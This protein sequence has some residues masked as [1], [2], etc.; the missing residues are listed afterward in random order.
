MAK[1]KKS[2]HSKKNTPEGF[3]SK[4]SLEEILPQKYHVLAVILVIFIL[5]LAFLYP[6]YFGGKTFESGD[7]IASKAMRPYVENH[8][9]GFT[10]WNPLIFC[11]MPA[12]AT[13]LGFKWFNLI[14]VS[15]ASVRD[16]FTSLFSVQ[17]T[18]WTFYLILLAIT[19][20]F[21]MKYI[22]K[23]TLVSLFSAIA[24]SF[25]TGIIVFLYIGHVTK[26]NSLCMF[27]L[28]FLMLLKFKEKIKVLDF[29]ILIIALQILLLGFHAQIIFYT[30]F[31]V[32][33]YFIFYILRS[34]FK[35]DNELR[36]SLFKSAG[37]FAVATIIAL[38]IQSDNISQIY[39]YTP[40][41]TRGTSS[42]VEKPTGQ[43][44][45][46][47]SGYYKYHTMWSFS[48]EEL[49]TFIIPSYYG[50]GSSTYQGPLTQER[51]VNVNT[52]FGQMEFVDVAMYMGI[53]VFFLA[54]F[55]VYSRRKEPFVQFLAV[56][57]IIALLISFGKNFPVVFDLL[58]Y[59]L[60]LFN[61]FRVPSMILVLV[62]LSVPILAGL[63]L[64]K[65][66]SLKDEKDAGLIKLIKNSAYIFT[67]IF[68]ISLLLKG[69][70]SDW[71]AG[72]V[73]DYAANLRGS[74][75][76]L[77]QQFQALAK[78]VASMFSGDLM[79]G[80]GILTIAFWMALAYINSKVSR[81]AFILVVIVLTILDLW[82]ID[83]RGEK[84]VDNPDVKG[85]FNQPS[86]IA[87][88]KNQN[89]KQPFRMLNLKQD[90]SL[91]S[92]NN[93]SNYNAYFMVEDF[94]GYSAIKPRAYQD[95]IDVIGPV[96]R[97]L[98]R[99]ANV[100]YIV[101]SKA[102]GI[103]GLIPI[104]SKKGEFVYQNQDALP[105]A[106]FVNKV[107]KIPEMQILKAIKANS[108]DPQN[109]AYVQSEKLS[110]DPPDL[111]ANVNI[112]EYKDENVKI[113]VHAS[114]NNFLFFGNTFFPVGWKAF[115][116]GKPTKIYRTDHDFMGVIVPEG[117]HNVT[118]KYSPTSFYIS[119]YVSLILSSAVILAIIIILL[120]R[121][122]ESKQGKVVTT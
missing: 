109:I 70:I 15:V 71:F 7:I 79:V 33:I 84:Y 78:Y 53:L 73:N 92:L 14:A 81:D 106:Y 115:I 96:N 38:L 101:T 8:G 28:I 22:T 18:M 82:R 120:L 32:G 3:W 68:I 80:F 66:I 50:F 19:S 1:T 48:P 110:V 17:Y 49:A 37:V 89:D 118:F 83:A 103:Q 34:L 39:Q 74:Q 64:M 91:G 61:K 94:Y 4:F 87:T 2:T 67:A 93:N 23:N 63:G 55:A 25:S 111:S 42:I 11:G 113:K 47:S 54:L 69:P 90:G 35:K 58:F 88:I 100:K 40:Y 105:R 36:N 99:L 95:L 86:Y 59:Y 46:S 121:F 119:K 29:L 104:E 16:A 85:M 107:E 27:P 98:W 112:E 9:S 30:F 116:D 45:P 20:F 51:P 5:F 41:S 31:A 76:R 75:P 72:R 62:Q 43:S 21:L 24:T 13:S 122:K 117:N 44:N 65:I 57:S 60:P 6:L 114:G 26:L 97:T 102:A 108:F 52:Y 10:L 12:Y 77:A 56:L